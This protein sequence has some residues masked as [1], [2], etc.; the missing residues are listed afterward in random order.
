MISRSYQVFDAAEAKP[1]FGHNPSPR[2]GNPFGPPK[3]KAF[4]M[5]DWLTVVIPLRHRRLNG[6]HLM[7]FDTHGALEW[8]APSRFQHEGTFSTSVVLKSQGSCPGD[9]NFAEEL[10]LDGN[11]TK[12]LQGHNVDGPDSVGL[13]VSEALCLVCR[14]LGIGFSVFD[15]YRV[16][17]G[18][19]SIKRIDIT[20]TMKVG[21][22]SLEV[23]TFLD[24]LGETGGTKYR[25]A[26]PDRGTV[27][28]NKGS[29]RW[30]SAWYNKA[31]EVKKRKPPKMTDQTFIQSWLYA[32]SASRRM[33]LWS[34]EDW[35]KLSELVEGCVRIEFKLQSLQ[36]ADMDLQEGFA[37]CSAFGR[38]GVE[39][40]TV[41]CEMMKR[42][43]INGNVRVKGSQL[44]EIPANVR[45][46]YEL[47]RSGVAVRELVSRATFYRH[48]AALKEF[49]IDIDQPPRETAQV[50]PIVR[51]L[52]AKP[53]R[54]D[55]PSEFA[56]LLR[57]V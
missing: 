16:S 42:I 57:A 39:P 13:I 25:K 8:E 19:F 37:W 44:D 52:E 26:Y 18:D 3:Q 46:T 22:K 38:D 56:G 20:Y 7:K 41:W 54:V 51:Y 15:L 24:A 34:N 21:D 1:F 2:R 31:K 49:G 33:K 47:W 43:Q 55:L 11:L 27:Y 30:S 40:Y 23:D 32:R 12:F 28:F 9:P 5:I 36:L 48:K 50:I 17:R 10:Y 35:F 4:T 53:H 45:G 14:E 6:G 29:R